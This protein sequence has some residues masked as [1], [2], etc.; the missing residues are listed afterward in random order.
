MKKPTLLLA[1]LPV[2]VLVSI[3]AVGV[4]LFG[5]NLTSGPSQVALITASIVGALIAMF[6]LKVPWERIEEGILDSLSKTG[7]AIFILLMIGALTSSWILS[8][9]V[10]TMIYYGLQ[11]ISPSIFLFVIFIFT[12]L[13]SLMAGSSWT[14]IGTIGVAML[15]AGEILGFHPGWLAGA[16]ISG[17]Y[18]GDKVSPLSDTTNLAASISEVNI[19]THIRYMLI[20]NIP[21]VIICAIIF[22]VAGFFVPVNAQLDVAQQCAEI[23]STFNISLWLLLIPGF[24]ILLI[25]K[26]VAPFITLFLSAV[27]GA[28]VALIVQPDIISQITPYGEG[29][30][31]RYIYAPL[32]MLSS[33]VT[34]STG[35]AMLDELA[36]TNGM[37]G[38][39][40]T[41]WLI[42]CVIAFG[43][44][45][46]ACGYITVVTERILKVMK[47]ATSLVASTIGTCIFCN[48]T[49]SDQYMSILLPGK[50]FGKAYRE[51][52]LAPQMLSR[53][54]EDSATVVSVLIP[55][56]TCGV[57]QASVL[58]VPTLVY[59]PYCFFNYLSPIVSIVVV[60]MGYKIARIALPDSKT[61]A[62]EEQKVT[63]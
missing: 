17:A 57:V 40:T 38:M 55:W 9:V 24:T 46:E 33:E 22:A 45:M 41:I 6:Y 31:M 28:V 18:L 14:T 35:N 32:K 4:Y 50:M 54:I 25:Y 34:I 49:L 42:L 52:G 3:I 59:L 39:L 19:Y 51:Q 13:I 11:I 56:N 47:G 37:S 30:I 1:M 61:K 43:G 62:S 60:A 20:T 12:A 44:M 7:S 21:T 48:L 15:G 27:V 5:D 8:G 16:I 23:A 36:S 10:P 63:A 58:G 2:I 53:S 26:K 29:E